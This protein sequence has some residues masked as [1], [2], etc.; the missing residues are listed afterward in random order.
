MAVVTDAGVEA[1]LRSGQDYYR[2]LAVGTGTPSN[3]GCGEEVDRVQIDSY[4]INGRTRTFKAYFTKEQAVG[5]LTEW[6]I[7]RRSDDTIA[8]MYGS[9]S[10]AV[11]KDDTKGLL[12]RSEEHTSELQSRENLVC[13]LLLEK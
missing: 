8:F 4:T 5:N 2:Y 11:V 6:A 1:T 13:R 12:V 9:W 7:H 10:E 3:A